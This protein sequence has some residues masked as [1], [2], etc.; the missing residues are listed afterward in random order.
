MKEATFSTICINVH[1]AFSYPLNTDSAMNPLYRAPLA[2]KVLTSEHN[3]VGGAA[4]WRYITRVAIL[5]KLEELHAVLSLENKRAEDA[6]TEAQG[7]ASSG[8]M[9][10]K[11]FEKSQTESSECITEMGSLDVDPEEREKELIRM[12]IERLDGARAIL[13]R[14]HALHGRRLMTDGSGGGR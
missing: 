9:T 3:E 8:T 6:Q 10:G 5:S 2:A 13:E 14:E 4:L 7:R 12:R 11:S 1:E